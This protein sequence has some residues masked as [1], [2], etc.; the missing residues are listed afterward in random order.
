LSPWIEYSLKVPSM[1]NINFSETYELTD[2]FEID[3]NELDGQ[4]NTDSFVLG[5]EWTQFRERLA[6]EPIEFSA[7]VHSANVQRVCNMASRRGRETKASWTFDGVVS[8]GWCL[9][10]VYPKKTLTLVKP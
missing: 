2:P 1:T 4:S 3:N 9:V 8:E 5:V 6:S 7:A 10:T